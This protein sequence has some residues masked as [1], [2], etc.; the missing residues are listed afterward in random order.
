MN[1]FGAVG[2][3]NHS[4]YLE[5][6]VQDKIVLRPSVSRRFFPSYRRATGSKE[7]NGGKEP[8]MNA[9]RERRVYQ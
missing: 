6:T 2:D 5:G 4:S 8:K 9:E 3:A 1:P 7:Y